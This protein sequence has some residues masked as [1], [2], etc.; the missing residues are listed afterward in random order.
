MSIN[1][2]V[3]SDMINSARATGISWYSRGLI[4]NLVSLEN[5][6]VMCF[7]IDG[8]SNLKEIQEK[9]AQH[10]DSSIKNFF[11]FLAKFGL[12]KRFM[13][14]LL[15]IRMRRSFQ[16]G[17][18]KLGKAIYLETNYI[19]MPIQFNGPTICTVYDLS[20]KAHPECHTA[21]TRRNL[22]TN[23]AQSIKT[24]TH[25]LTISEFSKRE[26]MTHYQVPADKIS[27]VSP[28]VSEKYHP[29]S[30]TEVEVTLK[31]YGLN[32]GKYLVCVGT[33]EPRKNLI[34]L[35]QAYAQLPEAIKTQ[36]PL[37]LVGGKGWLC[38]DIERE[39]QPLLADK[40]LVYVGYA[41]QQE[42]YDLYSGARASAYVSIY[43]GFG[44]PILEAMASGV[45]VLTS[46]CTSMPEVAGDAAILA[47][48]LDIND[49]SQKLLLLLT[50][51]N[52]RSDLISK[53]FNRITNYTWSKS[54][55]K[56]LQLLKKL[57]DI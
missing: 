18:A 10:K 50:D 23:L 43:E 13:K 55:E 48:P 39:M 27:I 52:L 8:W 44:M 31:K 36:Y 11:Y 22:N 3:K 9:Q 45:P 56:L 16:Q 37:V 33:I 6:N 51:E 5:I 7:S 4:E 32:Y 40:H 25:V 38:D 24:A 54:A 57:N 30:E 14:F 29:Q 46:N 17:V 15:F 12:L 34:N 1:L 20:F 2:I 49:I 21:E 28:G 26:I 19:L 53:G 41:P 35:M 47:D 42:V